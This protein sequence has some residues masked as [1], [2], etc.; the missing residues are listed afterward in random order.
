MKK[1]AI[2]EDEA[3]LRKM[4]TQKFTQEGIEVVTATTAEE[5]IGLIEK[6][7]P[8]LVLLDIILPRKDGTYLL[9]QI[10]KNPKTAKITVVAFSNYD[11][12]ETTKK[13][14]ELG[15]IAYLLKTDYTPSEIVKEVKKYLE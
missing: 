8:D 13:I 6:E 10:R 1:I 4:Y 7:M 14:K 2:I 12:P 3:V 15:A 9:E 5:G 11:N